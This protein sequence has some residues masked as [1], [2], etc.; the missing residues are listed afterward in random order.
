M[1]GARGCFNCGG[2]ALSLSSLST[3]S[4]T[5]H[6]PLRLSFSCTTTSSSSYPDLPIGDAADV[7]LNFFLHIT[8]KNRHVGGVR[9]RIYSVFK[10]NTTVLANFNSINT[11]EAHVVGHQAAQC[12][13]AGTPTC[14]N[15]GLE[16][17]VSRD[18]T[19]EAKPKSCYKCGQEGH[20]SR[21]C[22]DNAGSGGFSSGA[23]SG[24]RGGGAGAGTECYRCGKTGHIARA[25]PE[26]GGSSGGYSSG[27]GSSGAFGSNS[28]G[29]TCYTCGGV[30]HLSRDCVQGSKVGW[31]C[32]CRLDCYCWIPCAFSATIAAE[33]ATSAA[34]AP[35]HRSARVIRAGAR[36]TSRATAPAPP[37]LDLI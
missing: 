36:D 9:G 4:P 24:P 15:C 17:H 3:H 20:I 30:G 19:M 33:W 8:K 26:A 25:C 5:P 37:Q 12:P 2:C 13:K 31:S 32:F 22:P 35:K 7:D 34:T 6:V 21:D 29:K 14:Y 10:S 11:G 28:G 27:Y 1:S 18:C 23:P 16:G